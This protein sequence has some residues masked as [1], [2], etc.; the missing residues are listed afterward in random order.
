VSRSVVSRI[1]RGLGDRVLPVDL[2]RVAAPLGARVSVRLDW[3]GE[4]FDRLLDGE[5]AALVEVVVRLLTSAGWETAAEATFSVYGERG[6][7]D[8]FAF[9]RATSTA[10]VVEVKTVVPDMGSML[11]A[12]DRKRRLAPRIATERGWQASIVGRVL[13]MPANTTTRR[14]AAAAEATL[15]AELPARSIQVRRWINAPEGPISGIWFVPDALHMRTRRR[16]APKRPDSTHEP[17]P[18]LR[19]TRT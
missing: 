8:V 16:L 18:D 1:E 11:I 7:I 3:R 5:H 4:D 19:H 2:E 13:V 6:S 12:L 14:R 15:A 17:R 10:L 9:H